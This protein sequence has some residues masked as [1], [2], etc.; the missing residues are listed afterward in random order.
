MGSTLTKKC[1]SLNASEQMERLRMRQ[2]VP[3]FNSKV[4]AFNEEEEE[5]RFNQFD[6]SLITKLENVESRIYE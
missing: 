4:F 3:K 5:D 1:E 2:S 6:E